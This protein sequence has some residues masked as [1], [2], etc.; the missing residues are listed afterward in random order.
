MDTKLLKMPVKYKAPALR[1]ALLI[2]YKN[3]AINNN[4]KYYRKLYFAIFL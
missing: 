4:K 1:K 2:N 3:F